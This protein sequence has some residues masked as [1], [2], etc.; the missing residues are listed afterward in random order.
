MAIRR[1]E[2][3][4]TFSEDSTSTN[5]SASVTAPSGTDRVV[6]ASFSCQWV[7]FN[8]S[9][10]ITATWGGNAGTEL[11]QASTDTYGRGVSFYW[12]EADIPVGASTMS[13]SIG[14]FNEQAKTLIVSTYENV[15]QVAA[16]TSA[17]PLL[18]TTSP[19]TI[20]NLQEDTDVPRDNLILHVAHGGQPSGGAYSY[21]TTNAGTSN[22]TTATATISIG[23]SYRSG[24]ITFDSCASNTGASDNDLGAIFD[25]GD[26]NVG[27][28]SSNNW[29][30]RSSWIELT[31][32]VV[33]GGDYASTTTATSTVS[34][35]LAVDRD[36]IAAPAATSTV[37]G[38][39][40]NS[41][42]RYEST[43]TASSTVSGYLFTGTLDIV[44]TQTSVE[45]SLTTT[46]SPTLPSHVA[47][48]LLVVFVGMGDNGNVN[49]SSHLDGWRWN[50]SITLGS[51]DALVG[52][53]WKIAE[54]ASET[55]TL[56]ALASERW[57]SVAYQIKGADSAE[58]IFYTSEHGGLF[59]TSSSAPFEQI[60]MDKQ[61]EALSFVAVAG[62][63]DAI[64]TSAPTNYGNLTTL[65]GSALSAYGSLSTAYASIDTTTEAPADMPLSTTGGHATITFIV[66]KRD[67]DSETTFQRRFNFNDATSYFDTNTTGNTIVIDRYWTSPNWG[68]VEPIPSSTNGGPT[69]RTGADESFSTMRFEFGATG[70]ED[71]YVEFV[72][73]WEDLGVGANEGIVSIDDVSFWYDTSIAGTGS[74]RFG[75]ATNDAIEITDPNGT[76]TLVAKQTP[77]SATQGFLEETATPNL[78]CNYL[79][80]DSITIRIYG[81]V[82]S[83]GA[84]Q[85]LIRIDDLHFD[86][87]TLPNPKFFSTTVA[88]TSNVTGSV[89]IDKVFESTTNVASTVSA[90]FIINPNYFASTTSVAAT[91]TADV[92]YYV[93]YLVTSS[94]EHFI[95][96]D[97]TTAANCNLP[98]FQA[99]DMVLIIA[100]ALF[101]GTGYSA[102]GTLQT[103]R[104]NMSASKRYKIGLDQEGPSNGGGV[105]VGYFISETGSETASI[106]WSGG[107][108]GSTTL[109]DYSRA[110]HYYVF[111]GSETVPVDWAVCRQNQSDGGI[112]ISHEKSRNAQ[113]ITYAKPNAY[114][115]F[116][117]SPITGETAPTGFDNSQNLVT[118]YFV[119]DETFPANDAAQGLLY[120]NASA[121]ENSSSFNISGPW[122]SNGN[123]QDPTPVT[124]MI[125][126]YALRGS[127]TALGTNTVRVEFSDPSQ[128]NENTTSS[129]WARPGSTTYVSAVNTISVDDSRFAGTGSQTWDY[130]GVWT[131]FGLPAQSKVTRIVSGRYYYVYN[132]TSGSVGYGPLTVT[133]NGESTT[134]IA[135]QLTFNSGV[136]ETWGPVSTTAN[137]DVDLLATDSFNISMAATASGTIRN[138][139]SVPSITIEWERIPVDYASVINANSTITAQKIDRNR[140]YASTTSASSTVTANLEINRT[141]VSASVV[142][143]AVVE[144]TQFNATRPLISTTNALATPTGLFGATRP[145][146]STT[147]VVASASGEFFFGFEA[148]VSATSNVTAA[149][150][151][152]PIFAATV[153]AT[154][155]VGANEWRDISRE[156]AATVTATSALD[157]TAIERQVDWNSITSVAAAV[158]PTWER[159][160]RLD[161]VDINVN[162]NIDGNLQLAGKFQAII[163][164]VSALDPTVLGKTVNYISPISVTTEVNGNIVEGLRFVSATIAQSGVVLPTNL[165]VLRDLISTTNAISALSINDFDR[166]IEWDTSL[167]VASTVI[168]TIVVITNTLEL[169]WT[170]GLYF[171]EPEP[172]VLRL[173][174]DTYDDTVTVNEILDPSPRSDG[175]VLDPMIVDSDDDGP[176]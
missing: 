133:P 16:I 137:A 70:T 78:A 43:T 67:S 2:T 158:F 31:A 42:V 35:S 130:D 7:T 29:D 26:W 60:V 102:G 138:G 161:P 41:S 22:P 154:S 77:I 64:G 146:S 47:G 88:A 143:S 174:Q 113:Y 56:E 8:S 28:Q 128:Q 96:D 62:T 110:A 111:R 115:N 142:Q 36:M 50:Q 90:D 82:T 148:V 79:A 76:S 172:Y 163:N 15:D 19:Y 169:T 3:P 106:D 6:I 40:R 117:S 97:N 168:G 49:T 44:A 86:L 83:S 48:D 152:Q 147:N 38:D 155:T 166:A 109:G 123:T 134:T 175:D 145:I 176:A 173:T 101:G 27:A 100:G 45:D 18:D 46:F 149:F 66:F 164:A 165:E 9:G 91:V 127:S 61:R 114:T 52:V 10:T 5:F 162:A 170:S 159:F 14:G 99:G 12:K 156:F 37:T 93:N 105:E 34:G 116:G 21:S 84:G 118:D 125:A 122:S 104:V 150:D 39:V 53:A 124:G 119:K 73:T 63:Q 129:G 13:F 131:D 20:F 95:R 171:Y 4:Q 157:P 1:L 144:P 68:N 136:D 51:T 25:V 103:V 33:T 132:I 121:G 80:T 141:Y 107:S 87:T 139:W 120:S 65:Q 108:N 75:S 58:H 81:E 54:S 32:A 94:E 126:V 72:G 151:R 85:K 11:Y 112:T 160:V 17:S 135:P 92:D 55:L 57:K 30:T 89:D 71:N 69:G 140:G 153:S 23:A 59:T 98:S 74:V 24:V 167:A